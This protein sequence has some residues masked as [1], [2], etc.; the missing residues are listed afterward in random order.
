MAA[1]SHHR[2]RVA[3]AVVVLAWLIVTI[4]GFVRVENLASE[5]QERI[6]DVARLQLAFEKSSARSLELKTTVVC[7]QQNVVK[8]ATRHL[9][10][11]ELRER[12]HLGVVEHDVLLLVL[13]SL[14]PT[15]CSLDG[16][17]R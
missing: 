4:L 8:A 7:R 9:V 14:A 15:D 2:S 12:R 16:L 10:A 13:Q 5:N 6:R 17:G 11:L 1:D 3:L